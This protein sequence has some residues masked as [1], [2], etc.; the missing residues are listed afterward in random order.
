MKLDTLKSEAMK[1]TRAD[2]VSFATFILQTL[3]EEEDYATPEWLKAE[4]AERLAALDSGECLALDGEA[5]HR[6]IITTYG[7][8]IPDSSLR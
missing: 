8:Q 7:L 5:V 2:L 4:I 1:L 6:E 3:T